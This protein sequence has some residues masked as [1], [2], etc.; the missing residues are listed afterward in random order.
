M[1]TLENADSSWEVVDATC[2]LEGSDNNRW[3]WDE[4]VGESVVQVALHRT[5]SGYPPHVPF[6]SSRTL[7]CTN[8]QLK[9]I[10]HLLE[11]VLEPVTC[12]I[13]LLSDSMAVVIV[14]A[15]QPRL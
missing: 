10:L 12:Y 13:S 11:L 2:G 5:I 9:D 14:C 7:N 1:L 8:L 6:W 15:R 3:C 4:I